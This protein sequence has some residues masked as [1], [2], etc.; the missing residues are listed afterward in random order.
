[1]MSGQWLVKDLV[2]IAKVSK[3][4]ANVKS[5]IPPHNDNA[6]KRGGLQNRH[7]DVSDETRREACTKVYGDG[8]DKSDG[9]EL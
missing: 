4:A 9:L 3:G 1:M 5:R 6:H 2:E 8:A 7:R